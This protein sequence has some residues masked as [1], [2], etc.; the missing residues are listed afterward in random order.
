MVWYYCRS[1]YW[2]PTIYRYALFNPLLARN[3]LLK[4]LPCFPNKEFIDCTISKKQLFYMKLRE[5][6]NKKLEKSDG[7][8][9]SQSFI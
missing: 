6:R 2:V 9:T 7:I 3:L 1:I 5:N 4:K 8:S